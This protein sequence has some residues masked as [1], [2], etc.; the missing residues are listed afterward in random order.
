MY[1]ATVETSHILLCNLP[2][3]MWLKDVRA[4]CDWFTKWT[5]SGQVQ[6]LK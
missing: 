5:M 6:S 2:Q 3:L 1:I 4:Q